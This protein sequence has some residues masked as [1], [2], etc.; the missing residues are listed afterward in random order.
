MV[1]AYQ[2]A[3]KLLPSDPSLHLALAMA[4]SK[5]G[6]PSEA[7][8]HF[9]AAL[10]SAPESPQLMTIVGRVYA[11]IGRFD[12]AI[13]LYRKALERSPKS[14][15]IRLDLAV[16]LETKG[17]VAAAIE[18]YRRVLTQSAGSPA[19]ANNLAWLYATQP[20]ESHGNSAESLKLARQAC[21]ATEYQRPGYLDTL[22][23]A[24]AANGDFSAAV[25]VARKAVLLAAAM[26]QEELAKDLKARLQL[27]LAKMSYQEPAA[28]EP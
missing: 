4:L 18:Q 19:A 25:E 11:E 24:H 5:D 7:E 28:R 6:R 27:Y 10:A 17:D 2:K 13:E 21:E 15:P 1:G 26:G 16:A 3:L 14:V 23:A 9:R 20:D 8:E 22:A 12:R